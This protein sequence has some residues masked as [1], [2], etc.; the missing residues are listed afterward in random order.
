[1]SESPRFYGVVSAV[2]LTPWRKGAEVGNAAR[3]KRSETSVVAAFK[4]LRTHFAVG[5]R[6]GG[7]RERWQE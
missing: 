5:E 4:S 6:A 1:V 3:D 2:L 7:A